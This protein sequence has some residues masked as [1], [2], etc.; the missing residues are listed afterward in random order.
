M[1]NTSDF[2]NM[3]RHKMFYGELKKRKKKKD[4][5]D[6]IDEI[7][8]I[9]D[10]DEMDEYDNFWNA[11]NKTDLSLGDVL[12]TLDGICE[13]DGLVYVMTTNKREF[14]DPAL[15]RDGRITLDI[16]MGYMS[17]ECI[18]EM[19]CNMYFEEEIDYAKLDLLVHRIKENNI[20]PATLEGECMKMTFDELFEKYSY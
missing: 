9:D 8:E 14:L 17:I 7:D 13:Y 16:E 3:F 2:S 10:S 12:T 6:E 11:F 18:H 5:I 4:D 15:T 19:L 1:R 20:V